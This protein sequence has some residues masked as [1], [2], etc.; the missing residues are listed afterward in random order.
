MLSKP[1]YD[2]FLDRHIIL[3]PKDLIPDFDDRKPMPEG[4]LSFKHILTGIYR[5]HSTGAQVYTLTDEA[6]EVYAQFYDELASRARIARDSHQDDVRG[7]IMKAQV[8]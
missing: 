3:A 7:A 8:T 6:R 4:A 1:D 5:H 2:G